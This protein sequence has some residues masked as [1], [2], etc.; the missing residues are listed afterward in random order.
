MTYKLS[1]LLPE[2]RRSRIKGCLESGEYIVDQYIIKNLEEYLSLWKEVYTL[3]DGVSW[4]KILPYYDENIYFK[5]S[6]QEIQGIKAFTEM[7]ERLSQRSKD[8]EMKVHSSS[9]QDNLIF[10]EWEMIIS[11]KK[12]PKTSL[13]GVSRILLS[14]G[15][16]IEQRD[17]YDLWGDIFD[18][19]RFISGGY[20]KFM[21]R[22]FG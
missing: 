20:R 11:Y 13:Y 10:V 3:S 8:L 6:I 14:E 5:D 12:Y 22:K 4:K 19:I 21:R 17:Y 1:P 2:E 18:N 9:I 7:T 16:I 15:K